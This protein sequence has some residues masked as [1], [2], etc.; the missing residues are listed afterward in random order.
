[1]QPSELIEIPK[2]TLIYLEAAQ[3]NTKFNG[4]GEYPQHTHRRVDS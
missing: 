4:K 3:L 2:Y 1:M